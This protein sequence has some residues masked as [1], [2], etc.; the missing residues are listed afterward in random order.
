[1]GRYSIVDAARESMA[2]TSA[3]LLIPGNYPSD[4]R[5]DAALPGSNRSYAFPRLTPVDYKNDA[6]SALRVRTR[7]SSSI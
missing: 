4:I 7:N 6:P 1:M 2:G 3:A 5:G